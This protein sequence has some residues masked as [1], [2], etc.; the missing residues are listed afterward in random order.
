M[1]TA[2]I[3]QK[4][5]EIGSYRSSNETGGVLM[6]SYF[7]VCITLTENHFPQD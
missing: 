2:S 1:N 5:Q 7:L 6:I 3:R 4:P